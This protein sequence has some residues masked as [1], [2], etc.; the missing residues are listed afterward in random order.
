M[1][2][3]R[4]VT[5]LAKCLIEPHCY[6]IPSTQWH[7]RTPQEPP[8]ASGQ[9]AKCPRAVGDEILGVIGNSIP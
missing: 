2:V 3:V 6:V 1:V 5:N 8:R 4:I 7:P 9:G